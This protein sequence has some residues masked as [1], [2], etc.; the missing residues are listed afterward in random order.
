MSVEKAVMLAAHSVILFDERCV[1]SSS[2]IMLRKMLTLFGESSVRL[3]L[4]L[5][6]S[7]LFFEFFSIQAM[8]LLKNP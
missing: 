3:S 2:V 8:Q 1:L 5:V 6:A 4:L 7:L